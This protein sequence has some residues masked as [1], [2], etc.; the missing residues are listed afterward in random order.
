MK[1]Q[2]A[3]FKISEEIKCMS[4][5]DWTGLGDGS[6]QYGSPQKNL[7]VPYETQNIPSPAEQ[8]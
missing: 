7:Q 1:N 2:T 4:G 6:V 3:T 8:L 5:L